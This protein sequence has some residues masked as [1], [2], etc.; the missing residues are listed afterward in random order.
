MAWGRIDDQFHDH[1]KVLALANREDPLNVWVR[2]LSWCL[3]HSPDGIIPAGVAR[4]FGSDVALEQ[5]V[6]GGLWDRAEDG[7]AIH[8]FASYGRPTGSPKSTNAERQQRHRDRHRLGPKEDPPRYAVTPE[9]LRSVTESVTETVTRNADEG[10]TERYGVTPN[11]NDRNATSPR[12]GADPVPSRPVPSRVCDAR[13]HDAPA[14]ADGSAPA[15]VS[16]GAGAPARETL[17]TEEEHQVVRELEAG[18]DLWPSESLEAVAS[19][20]VLG[21]ARE[22][23]MKRDGVT[24]VIAAREGVLAA[25]A[26]ATRHPGRTPAMLLSDAEQEATRWIPM[27]CRKGEYR[28][29]EPRKAVDGLQKAN[30]EELVPGVL[31]ASRKARTW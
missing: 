20:I 4:A 14:R 18:R 28:V 30:G 21:V 12:A 9:P 5:L 31:R 15:G 3:R 13:A 1:P 11:R 16:A 26:K 22:P 6:A 19:R 7:F 8:D 27:R 29:V 10:V 17:P 2:T 24:A 25:R 23:A